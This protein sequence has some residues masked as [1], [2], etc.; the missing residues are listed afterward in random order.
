MKLWLNFILNKIIYVCLQKP[1][2]GW[3][4]ANRLFRFWKSS[5]A[6]KHKIAWS[7]TNQF[8]IFSS[9]GEWNGKLFFSA[10]VWFIISD[11]VFTLP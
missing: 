10:V 5:V 11:Q 3:G 9:F 1:T 2:G 6:D 4:Q 8:G 7:W